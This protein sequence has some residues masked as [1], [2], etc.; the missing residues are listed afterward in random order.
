MQ[1]N[2]LMDKIADDVQVRVYYDT[3]P[4]C[5]FKAWKITGEFNNPNVDFEITKDKVLVYLK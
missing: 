2:K 3:M 1:L 4:I 5:T